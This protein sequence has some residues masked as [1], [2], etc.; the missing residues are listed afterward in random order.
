MFGYKR[1]TALAAAGLLA[2]GMAACAPGEVIDDS[3]T[4]STAEAP[5]EEVP[6]EEVDPADFEGKSLNYLYFTD[7]PDEQ[8]TRDNIAAFEEEYGV[9]VELEILP[10]SDLVSQLNAR[11]SG[12]NAPDVVRLTG[13]GEF[14]N[15]LLPLDQYLGAD[16]ADEFLE[17]PIAATKNDDGQVIAVP[18]D[19]TL[20]GMFINVDMFEE[21]GVDLPDS[22]DPW[23]WDEM[24][25]AG[26]QVQEA[27]GS[28]YAFAM[29]KSGHRVATIL[30]QYGTAMLDNDGFALDKD[31]ATAALQPLID[32]M[33][34]D[35]MPRDF[36]IGSGSRYEGANEIYLAEET[37]L[38]MSGTWQVGQFAADAP[39]NWS[40]AP[41]PCAEECGGFPGGKFMAALS[42]S[43]EPA[44][45]AE[46]VRFMNDTE[47]Q[48][49][50][51]SV[52]GNLPTRQD[53]ADE[54][55]TYSPEAQ[56]A[57]DVFIEDLARTPAFGYEANGH[58]AFG[59]S[60]TVLVEEMSEVVVGNKDLSTA[61]DDIQTGV[62]GIVEEMGS[63]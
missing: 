15:D 52:S 56:E 62:E 63:W 27:T 48:E 41:N 22:S 30:S 34:D 33:A 45:A 57:M 36:W 35:T 31:Q 29:D 43:D 14:R 42:A 46:F 6:Q 23:T 13:L 2:F 38:Y 32:M 60:A 25:D 61:L 17:G 26:R 7:G 28:S 12:G 53:L 50:F 54:G 40:A 11:L 24:I 16:F 5:Q 39:F 58:P 21:A 51:A 37:P 55:V 49:H 3:D 19:L 8:A 9:T 59:P 1:F 18:S 4:D 44:L 20:N 47:R 10:Y